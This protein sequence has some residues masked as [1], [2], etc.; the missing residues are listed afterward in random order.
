MTTSHPFG[1]PHCSASFS[2]KTGLGVHKKRKHALEANDEVRTDLVKARWTS[3]E[4]SLMAFKEAELLASEWTAE[5]N[6]SLMLLFPNRSREAIKGQRKSKKRSA[7]N[8]AKNSNPSSKELAT[9]SSLSGT[10]SKIVE[11]PEPVLSSVIQLRSPVKKTVP[12]QS[13]SSVDSDEDTNSLLIEPVEL[14][15]PDMAQTR[16]M[17]E[18]LEL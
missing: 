14:D 15:S 18:D 13:S 8:L 9:N 4:L 6:S 10:L 1:C 16:F 17:S 2:T 7:R 3:E 12:I 5:I 11:V